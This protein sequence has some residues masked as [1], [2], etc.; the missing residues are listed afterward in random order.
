MTRRI[1]KSRRAT[2]SWTVAVAI[3]LVLSLSYAPAQAKKHTDFDLS[4]RAEFDSLLPL[5]SKQGTGPDV[6]TYLS[7]TGR[8]TE[9]HLMRVVGSCTEVGPAARWPRMRFILTVDSVGKVNEARADSTGML[10]GCIE[11]SWIGAQYKAPPF[12][13]FY[14]LVVME[15]KL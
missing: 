1:P 9:S 5:M 15:A 10:R 11:K 4:G 3:L 12:A 14:R 8:Q 2:N 7:E 13:P 6:R